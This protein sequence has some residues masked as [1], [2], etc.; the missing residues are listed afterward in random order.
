MEEPGFRGI[1]SVLSVMTLSECSK[2]LALEAEA[3]HTDSD[4]PA[5]ARVLTEALLVTSSASTRPSLRTRP[6]WASV[7]STLC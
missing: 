1:Q 4:G 5:N 6:Q 7:S 3:T 2:T